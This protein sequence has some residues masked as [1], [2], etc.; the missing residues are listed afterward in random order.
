[1]AT[2]IPADTAYPQFR[3][4]R[5]RGS[6][7]P[8]AVAAALLL[9]PAA[10][11][12]LKVSSRP[13]RPGRELPAQ[14]GAR[15]GRADA[16]AALV[17]EEPIT[18]DQLRPALAEAA[19]RLVLEEVI[20]DRL[21]DRELA[22]AGLRV[23]EADG[24]H[25]REALVEALGRDARADANDAERLIEDL[26]RSRGLGD[27]RFAA[28]LMRTAKL[29]RLVGTVA[30]TDE[31]VA[32]AHRMRH[33]PTYRTRVIAVPMERDAARIW[34]ALNAGDPATLAA[35]FAET[36][37]KESKD[38]S[39]PR[40]GLLGPVSPADPTYPAAVRGLMES[41]APG[42]MSP[43]FALENGYGIILVEE[44]IEGDGAALEAA[45]PGLR[46][47]LTKR[48][49]RLAMDELARRLLVGANVS[50]QDDHLRWSWEGRR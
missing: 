18:W 35:R 10:G 7:I 23:T 6:L 46:D 40:A 24:A 8:A 43:V 15:G 11:E 22:K 50:V 21:L 5:A 37:T 13:T 32:I 47:E 28:Q 20:L 4:G 38:P 45:A 42:T 29:R 48:R 44:R 34:T 19:G 25:E 49:E 39:A 2:R 9:P 1:M 16:I 31:E 17:N 14:P 26:R 30:V 3:P 33:G 41:L 12:V 36:A 27:A